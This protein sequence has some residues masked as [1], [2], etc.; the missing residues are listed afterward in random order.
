M[1]LY[2]FYGIVALIGLLYIYLNLKWSYWTKRGVYQLTPAFPFGTSTAKAFF[3]RSK[4]LNDTLREEAEETKNLPYY[5]GYMF[6]K[7]I[8]FV[9]D[10]EWVRQITIKD[11]DYF[12]DRNGTFFD[13]IFASG[14]LTDTIWQK[15]MTSAKG[16]EWKNLRSTFTPIFTSG[17]MKGKTMILKLNSY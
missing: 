6:D 13:K 10:A 16:D 7:P 9:R 12:V 8:L 14:T 3:N 2:I 5:G 1:L 17:K 4:A 15:Q 11:F